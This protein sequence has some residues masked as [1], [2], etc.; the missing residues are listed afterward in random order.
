MKTREEYIT[1]KAKELINTL[2]NLSDFIELESFLEET[3]KKI[4]RREEE[5][6]LV[7]ALDLLL[8][9][10][11]ELDKI[12]PLEINLEYPSL[13]ELYKKLREEDNK[14]L[15]F[16]YREDYLKFRKEIRGKIYSLKVYIST[17]ELE[18]IDLY[19]RAKGLYSLRYNIF[20][21]RVGY[22]R[23]EEYT[24]LFREAFP[25][26]KIF[27]YS[28]SIRVIFTLR[29]KELFP[30]LEKLEEDLEE[31]LDTREEGLEVGFSYSKK[32]LEDFRNFLKEKG[33]N[34]EPYYN[35]PYFYSIPSLRNKIKIIERFREEVG[36]SA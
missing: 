30:S 18:Y 29:I 19:P 8:G 21:S 22:L 16:P 3:S 15:E 26:A 25:K 7:E 27:S 6:T 2:D 9:K 13:G 32:E 28:N 20:F 4:Y 33:S 17:L 35:T 12:S 34:K 23:E 10:L 11:E 24:K 14:I 31:Y 5:L 1:K 36:Y